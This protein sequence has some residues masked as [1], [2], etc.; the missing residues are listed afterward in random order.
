MNESRL[1]A[2]ES[3]Y[4]AILELIDEMEELSQ[5]QDKVDVSCGIGRAW[6]V[7]LYEI[8]KL[9][10]IETCALFLADEE[11]HEF[12]LRHASPPDRGG[13]CKKEV[14][15]QIECNMF[16]WV[17]KRRQPAIVP[18]L[19]YKRRKT[20]I[21][22][23]LTTVKRT[24]GTVLV[25]TPV[26]ES[27]ITQENMKLLAVLAKQFALVMENTVL[28]EHLRKEHE[29]VQK[30]QAQVMQAEKLAS[31]GR[32]TAGASHE[33]LNP[34]NVISGHLQYLL[35]GKDL[36]PGQV[37][38]LRVM[39][40]QSDRI[41][42]I[43][44]ALLQFSRYPNRKVAEVDVNRLIESV[45][46]LVDY[47]VRFE[48][49]EIVKSLDPDLPVIKGDEERLSQVF[50]NLLSNAK[51]AMPEGGRME[52]STRALVEDTGPEEEAGSVEI[53]FQDTGCGIGEEDIHK[54]F[55]PFF[56]TKSAGSGTGLGLSV[57]YGIIQDEGGEISVKSRPG[58]GARFTILLPFSG[59]K[60]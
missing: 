36:S 17:L 26:E 24:L 19:V 46:S 1:R 42:R 30:A 4:Q 34:L 20:V 3:G 28:Y 58:E 12:V 47:E 43:V 32:L 18:S 41:A 38:S 31:I 45:F 23:P 35:M 33:I 51:D 44:K 11:T 60:D 59:K 5:F 22:L 16:S 21:M 8:K 37:K 15:F 6:S 40:E 29:S 2:L 25:F 57:S 52:V 7:F 13:M 14:D 49:I 56:T 10:N 39:K 27:A 55:D 48:D 54:I 50:F 9:I 53:V